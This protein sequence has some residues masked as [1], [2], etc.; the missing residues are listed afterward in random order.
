M[1][2][3]PILYQEGYLGKIGGYLNQNKVIQTLIRYCLY[4]HNCDRYQIGK[5][6]RQNLTKTTSTAN[7]ILFL[8]VREYMWLFYPTTRISE[9]GNTM[10]TSKMHGNWMCQM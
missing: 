3:K 2:T 8:L 9:Y 7:D 1:A 10:M 6:K 4:D 5:N